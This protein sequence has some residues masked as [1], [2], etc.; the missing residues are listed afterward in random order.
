MTALI[1][2]CGC[3]LAFTAEGWKAL[4]F[5]GWSDAYETEWPG[6]MALDEMRNC[7]CGSTIAIQRGVRQVLRELATAAKTLEGQTVEERNMLRTLAASQLV[8]LTLQVTQ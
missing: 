2:T 6:L 7:P 4:P 5:V 8:E 1:K 3:S